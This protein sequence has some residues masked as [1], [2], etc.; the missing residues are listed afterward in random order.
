MSDGCLNSPT[1]SPMLPKPRLLGRARCAD[2]DGVPVQGLADRK[3]CS[4]VVIVPDT[5]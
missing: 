5:A 4:D 2:V 3:R 1:V